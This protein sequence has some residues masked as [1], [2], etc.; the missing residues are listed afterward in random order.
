MDK[1]QKRIR[2]VQDEHATEVLAKHLTEH[3]QQQ[4][5]NALIKLGGFNVVNRIAQTLSSE[6]MRALIT[7]REEKLY[8]SLG[9]ENFTDFLNTSEYAPMSKSQFY[10]RKAVLEKEGD[11]TFD[12]LNNLAFP[13]IKRKQ[14]GAGHI[15]LDGDTVIVVSGEFG[16]E[17][18]EEINITDRAR[19]L[20]TLSALADAN[21]D[22]SKK[23]EKKQAQLEKSE[24]E[25]KRLDEDNDNILAHNKTDALDPH[26]AALLNL[27]GAFNQLKI[28]AEQLPEAEKSQFAP[29]VFQTIAAQMDTLSTG[30]GRNR[31]SL[32]VD[33]KNKPLMEMSDDERSRHVAKKLQGFAPD[34]NADEDIPVVAASI[35]DDELASLMD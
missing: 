33:V 22:K 31:I 34:N 15:Q 10:E 32:K 35:N 30:Y 18:T 28:T 27:V 7:F 23:L 4:R 13:V 21:A 24:A 9:Y 8:E 25:I 5:D 11:V 12:L 17:T 20:E 2:T 6:L 26:A 1:L 14:L 19:L 16:E 3:E 29:R